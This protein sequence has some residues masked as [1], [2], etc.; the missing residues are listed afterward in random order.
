M[1]MKLD[2]VLNLLE[3]FLYLLDDHLLFVLL[4]ELR[5]EVLQVQLHLVA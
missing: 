1:L 4:L 5:R 2:V 3:V